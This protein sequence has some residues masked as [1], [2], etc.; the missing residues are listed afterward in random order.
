MVDLPVVLGIE[1]VAHEHFVHALGFLGMEEA[2]FVVL[3]VGM[4]VDSQNVNRGWAA[5]RLVHNRKL[6]VPAL[7]RDLNS[8]SIVEVVDLGQRTELL[9]VLR[10]QDFQHPHVL[11]F[12]GTEIEL[13]HEGERFQLEKDF[14]GRH[15]EISGFPTDE[16]AGGFVEGLHDAL[17]VVG[18]RNQLVLHFAHTNYND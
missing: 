17:G 10:D 15:G 8:H 9:A 5:L 14:D 3:E 4:S 13:G 6:Y 2:V 16:A 7:P 12:L 1:P 11:V 18:S